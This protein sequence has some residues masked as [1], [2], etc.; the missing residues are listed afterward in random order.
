M[1]ASSSLRTQIIISINNATALVGLILLGPVLPPLSP[2]PRQHCPRLWCRKIGRE[3]LSGNRVVSF[4]Y[5][6][7]TDLPFCHHIKVI[8]VTVRCPM[9]FSTDVSCLFVC[10]SYP[11]FLCV[12]PS[13]ATWAALNFH[14]FIHLPLSADLGLYFFICSFRHD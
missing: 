5:L 11:G 1:S 12:V 8:H 9:S 6:P 7:I 2:H 14:S 10:V 13:F 4:S 3:S